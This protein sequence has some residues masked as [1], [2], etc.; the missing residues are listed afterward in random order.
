MNSQALFKCQR[1]ARR[2]LRKNMAHKTRTQA[3]R[4]TNAVSVHFG[5]IR[6][7]GRGETILSVDLSAGLQ[8]EIERQREGDRLDRCVHNCLEIPS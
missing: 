8:R 2:D 4:S 6:P 5:Q 1:S 7:V 3:T